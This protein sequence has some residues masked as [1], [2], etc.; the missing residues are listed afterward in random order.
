ML[1]LGLGLS[2]AVL[3]AACFLVLPWL[4]RR[5]FEG[6]GQERI[7]RF[8]WL[9][10]ALMG[11]AEL[12]EAM[13]IEGIVGAFFAGIGLNRLVP[14]RSALMERTHF[15]ASSLFIPGRPPFIASRRLFA[16]PRVECS[17]SRVTM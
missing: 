11:A 10:A 5:F 16:R 7:L 15:F 6:I 14:N 2:L 17:S 1:V 13:G 3:F 8:V 9:V 12:A 4:S